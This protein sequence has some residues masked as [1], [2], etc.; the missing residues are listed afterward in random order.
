MNFKNAEVFKI[1]ILDMKGQQVGLVDEKFFYKGKY[2]YSVD[3][4]Q[5]RSGSY[6]VEMVGEKKSYNHKFI[7]K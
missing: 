5:L 4:N 6:I 1:R 7:V 2:G 3:I